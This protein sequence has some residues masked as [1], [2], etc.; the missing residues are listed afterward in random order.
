[1]NE[2]RQ[3]E[4]FGENLALGHLRHL[5]PILTKDVGCIVRLDTLK[6]H[7]TPRFEAE[8]NVS[9]EAT[10]THNNKVWIKPMN[11]VKLAGRHRPMDV[12]PK[13]PDC[14]LK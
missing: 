14:H 10:F 12:T 11:I 8:G 2:P 5:R 9:V 1:M 7:K 6:N 13:I 4:V 3:M